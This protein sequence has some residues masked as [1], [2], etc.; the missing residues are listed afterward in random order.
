MK[1]RLD[2]VSKVTGW[3]FHD[4]RRTART[5]MTRLGVVRDQ[6]GAA[7]NHLSGRT[8]LER[9]YDRHDYAAGIIAAVTV[10]QGHV[11]GLV[12]AA[13]ELVRLSAQRQSG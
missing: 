4:L 6:A 10:R 9:T 2:A 8:A 11:A 5:G 12:G 1:E 13:G 7:I 3:R